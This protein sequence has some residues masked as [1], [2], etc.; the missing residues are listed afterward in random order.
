MYI[1]GWQKGHEQASKI[2][3]TGIAAKVTKDPDGYFKLQSHVPEQ[4]TFIGKCNTILLKQDPDGFT[5]NL[6]FTI[7]K[8]ATKPHKED[9]APFT[10]FMW[11][12]IEHTTC[13]LGVNLFFL[14]IHVVLTFQ[15]SMALW[16]VPQKPLHI[17]T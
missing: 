7:S 8:F 16:I 12:P 2:G 4:N 17:L 3:I 11:I 10:F 1:L 15:D 5:C 6:S 13:N 14:M 9:D